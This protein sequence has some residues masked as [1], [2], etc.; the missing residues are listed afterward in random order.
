MSAVILPFLLLSTNRMLINS[1]SWIVCAV[2]NFTGVSFSLSEFA[3]Y[4][5]QF[6]IY[7]MEIKHN[8]KIKCLEYPNLV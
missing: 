6:K 3:L 1:L 7:D 4:S 8:W 2:I 5:S